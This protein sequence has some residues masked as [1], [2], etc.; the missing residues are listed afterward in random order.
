MGG[1]SHPASRRSSVSVP[2]RCTH[3][4]TRRPPC[5]PQVVSSLLAGAA[6]GSLAGSGLADSLGRRKAFLLDAL[7]MLAGPL[8]SA[9]ATGLGGM[10]LGRLVT[11]VG[12]G[13]SSALVPLYIS[14]VCTAFAAVCCQGAAAAYHCTSWRSF[15]RC[16]CCW[17]VPVM[18]F[19]DTECFSCRCRCHPV[20]SIYPLSF[21]CILQALPASFPTAVP[22]A[23][24]APV[25]A[26]DLSHRPARHPWLH[27]PA[28]DL[29]GHPGC[30]TGQCGAASCQLASDVCAGRCTRC[31]AWTG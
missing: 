21:R 14:E 2:Q 19:M 13:L 16:L 25:P 27:Q 11:G 26:A 10:L 7:P 5:N 15:L 6:A 8:L 3:L 17:P 4:Y 18:L 1:F 9:V 28:H 22:P 23:S 12:I 31:A 20:I 24:C 30:P 29:R